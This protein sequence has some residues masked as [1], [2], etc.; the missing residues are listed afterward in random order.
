MGW[1]RV[2][3]GFSRSTWPLVS[4]RVYGPYSDW[5]LVLDANFSL[6]FKQGRMWDLIVSVPDHCLSFYLTIFNHLTIQDFV[7]KSEFRGGLESTRVRPRKKNCIF[8]YLRVSNF[9]TFRLPG[10]R[11]L[12]FVNHHI[13]MWNNMFWRSNLCQRIFVHP[14]IRM[15]LKKP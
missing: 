11:D 10:T 15:A 5:R 4:K 6:P 2:K 14:S 12:S 3:A 8:R 1:K 13:L 7:E 9:E